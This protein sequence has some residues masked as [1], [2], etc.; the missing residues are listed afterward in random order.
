MSEKV[1]KECILWK[2]VISLGKEILFISKYTGMAYPK[3]RGAFHD[4]P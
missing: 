2:N 1:G 3:C 4:V